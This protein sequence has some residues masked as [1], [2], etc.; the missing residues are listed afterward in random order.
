[1]RSFSCTF[2]MCQ[3][4]SF[5]FDSWWNSQLFLHLEH[6]LHIW[7][8]YALRMPTTIE[9]TTRRFGLLKRSWPQV[10]IS[11]RFGLVQFQKRGCFMG[12]WLKEANFSRLLHLQC[13]ASIDMKLVVWQGGKGHSYEVSGREATSQEYCKVNI[14]QIY[15]QWVVPC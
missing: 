12:W 3:L 14:G 13:P 15:L 10:A 8:E 2:V 11:Q 5:R 4:S 6:D 9:R 1:M 7:K